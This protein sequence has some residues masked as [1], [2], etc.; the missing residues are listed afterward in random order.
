MLLLCS[1]NRLKEGVGVVGVKL[2][3]CPHQGN[4]VFRFGQIDDVVRP[5]RNHMNRLDFFSRNLKSDLFVCVDIALLNQ[6]SA[7]YNNEKLPL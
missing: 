2:L 1:L 6:R 4:E 5:A 7:R 3:V